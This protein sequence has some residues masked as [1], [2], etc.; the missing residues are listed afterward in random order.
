MNI[1]EVREGLLPPGV[2]GELSRSTLPPKRPSRLRGGALLLGAGLLAFGGYKGY[3]ALTKGP[4][5]ATFGDAARVSAIFER[6]LK[7]GL[8]TKDPYGCSVDLEAAEPGRYGIVARIEMGGG[9]RYEHWRRDVDAQKVYRIEP[10]QL[11]DGATLAIAP[12]A[13]PIDMD[14]EL[15]K[16][17]EQA[18][19]VTAAELPRDDMAL[20]VDDG[21]G[22]TV[23]FDRDLTKTVNE[24]VGLKALR[25]KLL[26]Q[27]P[28]EH[29]LL[30][31]A[32]DVALQVTVNGT[33]AQ[34][35]AVARAL[36][37]DGAL[38][39]MRSASFRP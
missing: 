37:A 23:K 33:E 15:K 21:R 17:R 26:S 22:G 7:I 19:R 14:A 13:Q 5:E 31:R 38:D 6:P 12:P 1:D 34:A 18:A 39:A 28:S 11:G 20:L 24:A 16:V 8:R 9:S 10:L 27:P 35:R 25:E 29:R 30:V 36:R 3:R 2:R 32:N 4:C